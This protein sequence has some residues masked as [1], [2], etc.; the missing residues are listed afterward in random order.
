MDVDA[1]VEAVAR[2]LAKEDRIEICSD[3]IYRLSTYG[4]KAR[5]ALRVA[6]GALMEEL[7]SNCVTEDR[8]AFADERY[9][10]KYFGDYPLSDDQ[11][12]AVHTMHS[13]ALQIRSIRARAAEIE[14]RL[15]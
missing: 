10:Y 8:I 6:V 5:A 7:L 4:P 1:L 14:G 3:A 13:A 12:D 11:W 2:A 15:G 9:Q